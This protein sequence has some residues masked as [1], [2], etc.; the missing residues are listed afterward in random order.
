VRA[1]RRNCKG[2][3]RKTARKKSK[4]RIEPVGWFMK[5]A[6]LISVIYLLL[7]DTVFSV[8]PWLVMRSVIHAHSS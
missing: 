6:A 7:I 8:Q 1:L 4:Y 2:G 3:L 5:S